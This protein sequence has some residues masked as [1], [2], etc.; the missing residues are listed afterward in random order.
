LAVTISLFATAQQIVISSANS[1]NI[2]TYKTI[3]IGNQVWM[4]ENL[5][6]DQFRNGDQ[7]PEAKTNEE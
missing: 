1:N 3:T 6:V 5:N 2:K 4:T 7:I